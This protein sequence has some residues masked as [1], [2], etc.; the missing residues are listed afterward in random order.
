MLLLLPPQSMPE[1]VVPASFYQLQFLGVAPGSGKQ[2]SIVTMY[3][4]HSSSSVTAWLP[5]A[6][7]FYGTK[8]QNM[9][10]WHFRVHKI[11]I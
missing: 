3:V 6:G 2:S 11:K 9:C 4:T 1:H 7:H 10:F 5:L 8:S